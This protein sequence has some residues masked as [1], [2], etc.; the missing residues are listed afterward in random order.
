MDSHKEYRKDYLLCLFQFLLL[1]M[2]RTFSVFRN[3]SHLLKLFFFLPSFINSV[4]YFICDLSKPTNQLLWL[5]KLISY[6][7]EEQM[8]EFLYPSCSGFTLDFLTLT[9]LTWMTQKHR[10]TESSD[11]LGWKGPL[12]VLPTFL[13]KPAVLVSAGIEFSSQYLL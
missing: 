10:R 8:F 1:Y 3:I 5:F 4:Q 6:W 11:S 7:L 13:L 12:V 2:N 9:D